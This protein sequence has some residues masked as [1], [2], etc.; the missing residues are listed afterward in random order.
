MV[1]GAHPT[2]KR[3]YSFIVI[4]FIIFTLSPCLARTDNVFV[5]DI[6]E[7]YMD[8]LHTSTYSFQPEKWQKIELKW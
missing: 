7:K 5:G 6:G 4:S 1:G 3:I 8:Y 2:A